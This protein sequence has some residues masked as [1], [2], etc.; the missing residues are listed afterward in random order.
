M[1]WEID[2]NSGNQPNCS[3]DHRSLQLVINQSKQTRNII[4]VVFV[5]TIV[6]QTY[7]LWI[8]GPDASQAR[9]TNIAFRLLCVLNIVLINHQHLYIF[10]CLTLLTTTKCRQ[11]IKSLSSWH[12]GLAQVLRAHRHPAIE[13]LGLINWFVEA[14]HMISYS[15]II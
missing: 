10:L 14:N 15:N 11:Q 4:L 5:F 2:G 1:H 9:T 13:L 8:S 7:I 12:R 6:Q 3:C